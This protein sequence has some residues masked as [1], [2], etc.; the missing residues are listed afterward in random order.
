MVNIAK[1]SL[2]G[3]RHFYS[4]AGAGGDMTTQVRATPPIYPGPYS[5]SADW[6]NAGCLTQD[7]QISA[8]P[9]NLEV[10]WVK[11]SG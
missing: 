6:T 7:S 5:S 3:I 9:R 10:I 8:C 1:K 2:Q 11:G 4:S